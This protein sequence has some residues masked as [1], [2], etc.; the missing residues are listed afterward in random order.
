MPGFSRQIASLGGTLGSE[1]SGLEPSQQHSDE[2]ARVYARLEGLESRNQSNICDE[3][4]ISALDEGLQY[5]NERI[6]AIEKAAQNQ[7]ASPQPPARGRPGPRRVSHAEEP[8]MSQLMSMREEIQR[9]RGRLVGVEQTLEQLPGKA[10]KDDPKDNSADL[11]DFFDKKLQEVYDFVKQG[12]DDNRNQGA[13]LLKAIRDSQRTTDLT[14]SKLVDLA[15]DLSKLQSRFEASVPQ[16]LHLVLELSR[17]GGGGTGEAYGDGL[18]DDLDEDRSSVA[19][20]VSALQDLL[21][22]YADGSGVPFVSPIIMREALAGF[23]QLIQSQIEKIQQDMISDLYNKADREETSSMSAQLQSAQQRIQVIG[24]HLFK[25]LSSKD[26][27][28]GEA[29]ALSRMQLC[30]RCLSCDKAVDLKGKWRSIDWDRFA[31]GSPRPG[32]PL[33]SEGR[34]FSG[35]RRHIEQTLPA[36][37]YG[38]TR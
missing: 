14:R 37:D 23:E 36:V 35:L 29:A 18:I 27:P 9:F 12:S 26:Q 11:K 32:S 19:R 15:S 3:E 13:N 21:Y 25:I 24:Q 38:R 31:G 34:P 8:G 20:A 28:D 7:P 22:G 16:L 17:R 1:V 10:A 4:H 6:V 30:G 2:L 33:S 5:L